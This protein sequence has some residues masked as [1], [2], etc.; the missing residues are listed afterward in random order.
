[1]NLLEIRTLFKETSGRMDL[2]DAQANFYIQAGQRY[3]DRLLTIKQFKKYHLRTIK[4]GDYMISFQGC[5]IISNVWIVDSD[6]K[7]SPLQKL[8]FDDLRQLYV[9]PHDGEVRGIPLYYAEANIRATPNDVNMEANPPTAVYDVYGELSR[10]ES[11]EEVN[12]LI[13]D[14]I[15]VLG[16]GQ[17]RSDAV[18]LYPVSNNTYSI[19]V[20]GIFY[21]DT[22]DSDEAESVWSVRYPEILLMGAMY[23]VEVYNRNSEGRKDWETAIQFEVNNIETDDVSSGVTHKLVME[24]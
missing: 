7:K 17:N 3:L 18:A 21:S 24:G 15:D 12:D 10:F 14:N 20:E 1:M 22:L 16:E 4:S 5:R 2:T 19:E 8:N 11:T 9:H 23:W 13:A 6:G